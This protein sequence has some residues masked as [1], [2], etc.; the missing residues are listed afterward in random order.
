M[1]EPISRLVGSSRD[2]S[3]VWRLPT[4]RFQHAFTLL[5]SLQELGE[6][7]GGDDDPSRR[8]AGEPVVFFF[9]L[10]FYLFFQFFFSFNCCC[11]CWRLPRQMCCSFFCLERGRVSKQAKWHVVVVVV[12][13]LVSGRH[14]NSDV[15]CSR[16]AS[17]LLLPCLG[18]GE[19]RKE[20][21]HEVQN[22]VITAWLL[23]A[24]AVWLEWAG[25]DC[26]RCPPP[27]RKLKRFRRVL[28]ASASAS[29]SSFFL[30]PFLLSICG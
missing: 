22:N 9:S 3:R 27:P 21:T 1:D 6:E 10:F 26:C 4:F 24:S 20:S 18:V 29:F 13:V 23:V 25:E 17:L 12:V 15:A 16:E 19:P 5:P 28:S 11:C 2:F 14:G 7:G 30:D 8:M